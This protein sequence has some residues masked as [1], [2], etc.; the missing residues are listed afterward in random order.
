M[1]MYW[2][3]P[4][5]GTFIAMNLFGPEVRSMWRWRKENLTVLLDGMAEQNF[6]QIGNIYRE[7]MEKLKI[8]KVPVQL[9]E[10]ETAIVKRVVYD[11]KSDQL[12]GFCGVEEDEHKCIADFVVD[13]GDGAIVSILILCDTNG[14]QSACFTKGILRVYWVP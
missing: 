13:I 14:K 4:R 3:G 12:I 9:S 7:A 10:D 2:G 5:L 6:K 11:E 8:G 1:I